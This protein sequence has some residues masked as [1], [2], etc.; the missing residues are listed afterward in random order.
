[1]KELIHITK[2]AQKKLTEL[3]LKHKNKNIFFS[4][5]GGGCNSF[6]YHTKM[7]KNSFKY[8]LEPMIYEPTKLMHCMKQPNYNLYICE[9]SLKHVIYTTID[10][11]SSFMNDTFTFDNPNA[12]YTYK[13]KNS[14]I[15]K[16]K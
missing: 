2:T 8:N 3:S 6:T 16:Y 10:W 13:C 11:K 9:Y 7:D 15:S 5:K 12:K 1:M 4:V 14:F